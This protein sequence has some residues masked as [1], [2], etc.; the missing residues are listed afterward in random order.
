MNSSQK[1]LEI[2]IETERVADKILQNKQEIIALDK[3]RQDTREAIRKVEQSDEN[4][5]WLTVGSLLIKM[6]KEKA[7]ELLTKGWFFWFNIISDF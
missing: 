4:K 7:L 1:T 3:R 5:T 2:L 6:T